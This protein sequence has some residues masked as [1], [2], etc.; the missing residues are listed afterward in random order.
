MTSPLNTYSTAPAR[1]LPSKG[2]Y[3]A[4]VPLKTFWTA[5]SLIVRSSFAEGSLILRHILGCA[6]SPTFLR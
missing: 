4:V 6:S 1:G 3:A 2:G 5:S